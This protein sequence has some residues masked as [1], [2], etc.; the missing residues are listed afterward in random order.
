[1]SEVDFLLYENP[2]IAL[3]HLKILIYIYIYI[4][5]RHTKKKTAKSSIRA[6]AKD[7][8]AKNDKTTQRET[9][10]KIVRS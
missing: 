2:T 10:S 3:T 8:G 6:T 1:M 7:D 5:L 4:V 9:Y